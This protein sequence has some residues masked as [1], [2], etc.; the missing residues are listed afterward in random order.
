MDVLGR[1]ADKLMFTCPFKIKTYGGQ[2]CIRG[3]GVV[4]N[5]ALPMH[6]GYSLS[7]YYHH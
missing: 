3:R 5:A 4:P 7:E 2:I 1:N 6:S